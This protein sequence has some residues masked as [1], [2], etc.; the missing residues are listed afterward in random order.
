MAVMNTLSDKL[1][2]QWT[3]I[4]RAIQLANSNPDL[5]PQV[6][7]LIDAYFIVVDEMVNELER[8]RMM[9]NPKIWSI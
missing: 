1:M 9:G 7:L 2:T 8:R 3:R 6:E 4:E 5:R